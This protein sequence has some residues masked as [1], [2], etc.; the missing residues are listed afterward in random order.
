MRTALDHR[1]L[2][3][4]AEVYRDAYGEAE[5]VSDLVPFMLQ[6]FLDSDGGFAKPRRRGDAVSTSREPRDGQQPA[7]DDEC[8]LCVMVDRAM[9]MLD[10]GKTKLYEL[11][12]AGELETIHIGRGT[13]V[14]RASIEALVER[15]R[16]GDETRSDDADIRLPRM[17]NR[18]TPAQARD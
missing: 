16:Q 8:A 17:S 13:L 9:R 14:L 4:F 18:Q 10:I 5:A 3:D 11:I 7:S 2:R 1:A 15:L 12:A 6:S